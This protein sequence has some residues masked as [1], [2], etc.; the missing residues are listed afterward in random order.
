MKSNLKWIIIFAALCLIC[1]FIIV[2]AGH[3]SGET[4]EIIVDGEVIR[5]VD[6]SE[7]CEFNIDLGDGEFNRISVKDGRIA[8][9]DASC[10]DKL[11][12]R[13]G[14]ISGGGI[15]IVCL[16][17]RLTVQITGDSGIDAVTGR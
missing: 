10:P 3:R 6:L 15:P 5:T 4:A 16:P 9:I 13:R 8:V 17:H 2:I 11:C 7:A 14:Y 12:V 1:G